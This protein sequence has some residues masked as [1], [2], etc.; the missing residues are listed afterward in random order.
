MADRTVP[1]AASSPEAAEYKMEDVTP[2]PTLFQ[3]RTCSGVNSPL[4]LRYI[5]DCQS[6]APATGRSS[7]PDLESQGSESIFSRTDSISS[8]GSH[9]ADSDILGAPNVP[10]HHGSIR[11]EPQPTTV[12]PP[13]ADR[14]TTQIHW[15]LPASRPFAPTVLPTSQMFNKPHPYRARALPSMESKRTVTGSSPGP[16]QSPPDLPSVVKN[17]KRQQTFPLGRTPPSAGEPMVFAH[18]KNSAPPG[19]LF[20]LDHPCMA[21]KTFL[22][23]VDANPIGSSSHP[24]EVG[25]VTKP[26]EAG[27]WNTD[28]LRAPVTFCAGNS[29]VEDEPLYTTSLSHLAWEDP[30]DVSDDKS[31]LDMD[32]IYDNLLEGVSNTISRIVGDAGLLKL[33]C[34]MENYIHDF[35]QC[36]LNDA[37][38][39]DSIH[40][41]ENEEQACDSGSHVLCHPGGLSTQGTRKRGTSSNGTTKRKT[42]HGQMTTHQTQSS[43]SADPSSQENDLPHIKIG[44]KPKMSPVG[45]YLSCPFRK[46]NPTKFNI[47]EWTCATQP[48]SDLALLKYVNTHTPVRFGVQFANITQGVTSRRSIPGKVVCRNAR[49]ARRRLRVWRSWNVTNAKLIPVSSKKSM[50]TMTIQRTESHPKW[51]SSWLKGKARLK[52]L[53]TRTFGEQYSPVMRMTRSQTQVSKRSLE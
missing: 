15:R 44:K 46:R 21:Q 25:Y 13:Y 6:F 35:L 38:P 45:D 37:L 9:W 19:T 26:L 42:M 47:R 34:P 53:P 36:M 24:G 30:E 18:R 5:A 7:T 22:N 10:V 20:S 52:C 31:P 11:T 28:A 8:F 29:K 14:K 3:R 23:G 1:D 33:K 39:C 27:I 41:D 43:D 40:E 12:E 2:M 17:A 51:H 49:V 48:Y 50:T 4:E 32:S 16:G